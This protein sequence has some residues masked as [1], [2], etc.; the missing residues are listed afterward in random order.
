MLNFYAIPTL[1]AS[2]IVS[3]IAIHFENLIIAEVAIFVRL[4]DF[5]NMFFCLVQAV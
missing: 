3:S 1:K 4:V 5:Q 2:T